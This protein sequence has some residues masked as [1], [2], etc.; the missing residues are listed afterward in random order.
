MCAEVNDWFQESPLCGHNPWVVD[1]AHISR[2]LY[3]ERRTVSAVQDSETVPGVT[4]ISFFLFLLVLD[5]KIIMPMK[6]VHFVQSRTK[7][8]NRKKEKEWSQWRQAWGQPF[9][10]RVR[11]FLSLFLFII[12]SRPDQRSPL[13]GNNML[14]LELY[15]E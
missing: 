3:A 15:D 6:L 7:K 5:H 13:R 12:K 14:G 8:K 4:R 11:P 10:L 9:T 2:N 1:Y